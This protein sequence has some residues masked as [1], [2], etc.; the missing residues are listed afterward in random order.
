[1]SQDIMSLL[2]DDPVLGRYVENTTPPVKA[3]LAASEG[4]NTERLVRERELS[5]SLGIPVR[6]I[7]GNMEKA[8]QEDLARRIQ[9]DPV[10]GRYAGLSPENA[11]LV[12]DDEQGLL[13]VIRAAASAAWESTKE[14][15]RD[16][17][18]AWDAG[19]RQMELAELG[20]RLADGDESAQ[21]EIDA[22]YAREASFPKMEESIR[23]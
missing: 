3:A 21:A 1:M 18:E 22:R 7:R 10:L 9:A 2:R 15:G 8:E 23:P 6:L 17:G 5:S 20:N 4:L 12:R 14:A 11:A 19:N 16:I 13:G